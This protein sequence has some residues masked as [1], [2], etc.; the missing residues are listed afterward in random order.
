MEGQELASTSPPDDTG[1]KTSQPV[2][3]APTI[4][5]VGSGDVYPPGQ[6]VPDTPNPPQPHDPVYPSTGHHY[7]CN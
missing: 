2:A 7:Q 1:Y 6:E 3:V 4:P 5:P